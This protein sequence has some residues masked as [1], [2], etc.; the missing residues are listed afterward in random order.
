MPLIL[1]NRIIELVFLIAVSQHL[2]PMSM[3]AITKN[4]T[5]IIFDLE[6]YNTYTGYYHCI[7]LRII[8]CMFGHV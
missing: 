6:Y 4:P 5:T 7:N 8:T 1:Q 2:S 3:T